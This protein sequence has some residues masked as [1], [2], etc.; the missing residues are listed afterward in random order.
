MMRNKILEEIQPDSTASDPDPTPAE[1]GSVAERAVERALAARRAAYA[2]EV[3][4]LLDASFRLIERRGDLEP[5]VSEIVR[6]AGLSNQAFYRHF[7]SK[8]ALL[9][10]V[11]DEGVQRLAAYLTGRMARATDPL[12]RIAEWLRGM[13]EQALHGDGAAA[14]RPFALARGRLAEAFPGEI[15]HSE[16]RLAGLAEH[17]IAAARDAGAL[18]QADPQRDAET[19]YHLAM[20]WMQA[21]LLEAEPARR[22]DAERL[23]DFAMHGLRRS[24]EAGAWNAR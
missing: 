2:D 17:A 1:S 6:E 4:R 9:L 8:Q 11:L 23:V 20:G 24:G 3:R 5:R 19:L 15:G 12:E 10:A 22:E 21:R 14:T 18:P 7:P 16:R 13:T